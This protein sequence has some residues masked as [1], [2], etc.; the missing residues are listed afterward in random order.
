MEISRWKWKNYEIVCWCVCVCFG[1][2]TNIWY[3]FDANNSHNMLVNVW[4]GAQFVLF[5]IGIAF[6]FSSFF[7][8][9]IDAARKQWTNS[10]P[11]AHIHFLHVCVRVCEHLFASEWQTLSPFA[12]I[13]HSVCVR[14][15]DS[16]TT[17][18]NRN[19]GFLYPGHPVW[20]VFKSTKAK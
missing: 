11:R 19:G 14:Y 13:L 20:A 9:W 16:A 4:F 3:V 17:A 18:I 8:V 15:E 7:F 5:F 12:T 10:T 1:V 6:N 2:H